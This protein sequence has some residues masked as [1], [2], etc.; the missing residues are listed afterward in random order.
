MALPAFLMVVPTLENSIPIS[1]DLAPVII[2]CLLPY[3]GIVYLSR[4]KD[5]Y[6]LRLL[7]LP[8][9]A[10]CSVLTAAFIAMCAFAVISKCLRLAFMRDGALKVDE[11]SLDERHLG[12]VNHGCILTLILDLCG[13]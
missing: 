12:I 4:Q 8:V 11:T 10:I 3:V 1:S 5:T 2:V 6:I 7:F 13:V 9:I